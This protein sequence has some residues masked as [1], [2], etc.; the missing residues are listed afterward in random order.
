MPVSSSKQMGKPDV[1]SIE[2]LSPAIS[3]EQKSTS[4]NSPVPTVGNRD[5]NLRLSRLLFARV[6]HPSCFQW[7]RGN[8][9]RRP[10]SRWWMPLACCRKGA[11]FSYWPRSS[12][13]GKES[14]G[15]KLLDMRPGRLRSEPGSMVSWLSWA[16]TLR[17]IKQKENTTIEIVGRSAGDETGRGVDETVWPI[18]W[19]LSLKLAG[20]LVG[21]LTEQW[22]SVALIARS[23][24]ASLRCQLSGNHAACLFVQQ[25]ARS[26]SGLRRHRLM[27]WRLAVQTMKT[28]RCWNPAGLQ[29]RQGCGPKSLSVKVATRSDRGDH[30]ISP[31]EPL[32]TSSVR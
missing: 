21:V 14:I 10:C 6:G 31:C 11:N 17:S 8:H 24:P 27:P 12:A 25:P 20:G 22:E 23:S 2:G 13:A 15:K 7:R 9:C 32:P 29:G 5:G 16:R 26:L 4:H 1:D 19:K 30:G 18:R 28:S 3:I